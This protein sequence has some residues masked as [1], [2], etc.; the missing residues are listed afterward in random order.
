MLDHLFFD[1]DFETY[2]DA[3]FED[4]NYTSEQMKRTNSVSLRDPL[5]LICLNIVCSYKFDAEIRTN[6]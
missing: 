3:L 4:Q 5:Y 2:K 1:L 6:N